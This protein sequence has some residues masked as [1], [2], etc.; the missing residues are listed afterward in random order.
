VLRL[1]IEN[2]LAGRPTALDYGKGCYRQYVYLDDVV[3]AVLAAL[4]RPN[5][6]RPAYNVTAGTRVALDEVAAAV[7]RTLPGARIEL[8]DR[9]HP[10]DYP[11]G[12]LDVTA[13]REDLGY[14]PAVSLDDG[15]RRYVD[16]MKARA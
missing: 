15:I 8:G 10:L 12:P 1:M 9:P 7:T 5:L 2:A 3:E 14:V 11:I 16:W 13:A 6:P 4:S